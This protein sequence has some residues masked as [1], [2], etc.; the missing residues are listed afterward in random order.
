MVG[1]NSRMAVTRPDKGPVSSVA[2]FIWKLHVNTAKTKVLV[3]SRGKLRRL[4]EFT[5]VSNKPL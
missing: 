4:Q 5:F 1:S 2:S 3:F